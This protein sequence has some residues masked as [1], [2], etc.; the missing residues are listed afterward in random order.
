MS[1]TVWSKT[2]CV[3][4]NAV[5]RQL[6]KGNVPFEEKMLEDHPEQLEAFKAAGLMQAPVVVATG[7]ET[8][9]GNNP[10]AVAAVVTKYGTK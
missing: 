3:Q 4:C 9:A 1:V 7:V 5:K 6:K 2:P 10:D 8:F